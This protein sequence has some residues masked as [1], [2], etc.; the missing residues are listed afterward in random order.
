MTKQQQLRRIAELESR[1]KDH[2]VDGSVLVFDWSDEHRRR[3]RGF[4]ADQVAE[5]LRPEG[6]KNA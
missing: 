3:W 2:Q 1:R 6:V 4:D 5:A